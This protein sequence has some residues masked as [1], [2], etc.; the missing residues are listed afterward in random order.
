MCARR[1]YTQ[2]IDVFEDESAKP[3][4]ALIPKADRRKYWDDKAMVGYFIGYANR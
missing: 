1:V 4:Y 3:I 2:L